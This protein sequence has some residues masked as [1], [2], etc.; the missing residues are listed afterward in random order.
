MCPICRLDREWAYQRYHTC[1]EVPARNLS[2]LSSVD[3]KADSEAQRV[4][5]SVGASFN[6]FVP[7]DVRWELE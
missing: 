7:A 5:A 1:N 3:D 2:I 6:Q 4:G